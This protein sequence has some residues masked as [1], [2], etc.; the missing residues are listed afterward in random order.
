MTR[1][2]LTEQQT[3]LILRRA[4]LKDQLEQIE[5]GLKQINFGLALLNE[6]EKKAEQEDPKE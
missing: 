1:E 4:A 5:D 2:Q 3:Q 6:N